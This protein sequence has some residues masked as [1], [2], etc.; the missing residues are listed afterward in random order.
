MWMLIFNSG[1]FCFFA[2]LFVLLLTIINFYTWF[3]VYSTYKTLEGKKGLTHEV[4]FVK[5][6]YA[7][8]PIIENTKLQNNV[9]QP[10][11]V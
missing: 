4:Y 9:P 7:S 8:P 10:F 5:K 2:G 1:Q 3:V 6:Q 11:D